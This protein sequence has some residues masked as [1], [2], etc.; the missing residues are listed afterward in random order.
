MNTSERLRAIADWLDEHGLADYP[1]LAFTHDSVGLHGIDDRMLL[2]RLLRLLKDPQ[3]H[4]SSSTHWIAGEVTLAGEAVD[5]TLFYRA[6]LLGETTRTT[7]V[8]VE[9]SQDLAG[10]LAEVPA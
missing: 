3:A 2:G 10:L 5:L 4:R 6:G 7:V 1:R 8:E 9:Q